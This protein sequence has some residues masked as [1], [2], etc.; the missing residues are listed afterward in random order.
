MSAS[1]QPVSG[2]SDGQFP[3]CLR[4]PLEIPYGEHSALRGRAISSL[5]LR[6]LSKLVHR[7]PDLPRLLRRRYRCSKQER[8][9]FSVPRAR[10]LFRWCFIKQDQYRL[11]GKIGSLLEVENGE[12]ARSWDMQESEWYAL[13]VRPRFELVAAFYLHSRNIEQYLPLRRV[14]RQLANGTR[15]IELPLLPG[16][17]FCK[18]SPRMLSSLLTIPG[19][20]HI[21]AD[22]ISD[23]KISELKRVIR[24]GLLRRQPNQAHLRT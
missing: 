9:L 15:S 11:F 6:R 20:M 19:V 21:A 7:V 14:T 4:D 12:P 5:P 23:Q 3:Y 17:V 22:R 8:T 18:A 2:R 13:H 10:W 24:A 1:V 16:Y